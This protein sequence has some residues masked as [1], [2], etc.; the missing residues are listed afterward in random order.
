MNKSH[1]FILLVILSGC[2]GE[3][4]FSTSKNF[5]HLAIRS[6][7]LKANYLQINS[8]LLYKISSL[9]DYKSSNC[10]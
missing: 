9:L 10:I 3:G 2:G 1:L 8:N 7:N 6:S 5:A 4:K